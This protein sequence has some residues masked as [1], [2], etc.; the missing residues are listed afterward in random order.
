MKV[1]NSQAGESE[2]QFRLQ[3]GDHIPQ[4]ILAEVGQG[5]RRMK[6]TCSFILFLGVLC[7]MGCKA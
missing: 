5:P 4:R 2:K 3:L 1:L 6:E 7:D